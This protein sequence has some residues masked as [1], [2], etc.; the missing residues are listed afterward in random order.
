MVLKPTADQSIVMEQIGL[1][2][3][4]LLV[5]QEPVCKCLTKRG[6]RRTNRQVLEIILDLPTP[7]FEIENS[8]STKGTCVMMMPSK[9]E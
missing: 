6:G 4:S 7:F 8:S 5:A 9:R 1:S 2:L 3:S